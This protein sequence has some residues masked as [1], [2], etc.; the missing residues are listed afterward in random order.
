M[1]IQHSLD[2]VRVALDIHAVGGD[3]RDRKQRHEVVDD[4]AFVLLPP[5]SPRERRRVCLGGNRS[6]YQ[7]EESHEPRRAQ[8]PTA[9][10]DRC[11]SRCADARWCRRAFIADT[12]F[13]SKEIA[14]WPCRGYEMADATGIQ[15]GGRGDIGLAGRA[16][17]VRCRI[18]NVCVAGDW[19]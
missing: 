8:Y 6:G 17:N 4:C 3:V 1:L 18:R 7:S 10:V 15:G 16:S 14:C 13:C 19:T 12:Q 9:V 11:G 2:L 5:L